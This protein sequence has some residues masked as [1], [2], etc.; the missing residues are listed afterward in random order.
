[1]LVDQLSWQWIFFVNVPIGVIAFGLDIWSQWRGLCTGNPPLPVLTLALA[2]Y[3]AQELHR[4]IG[5]QQGGQGAQQS[6]H[7]EGRQ[8]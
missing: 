4:P 6:H 7:D 3:G 8:G 1:M 2:E 5:G